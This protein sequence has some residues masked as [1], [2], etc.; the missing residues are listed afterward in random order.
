L[1]LKLLRDRD[2]P[3]VVKNGGAHIIVNGRIDFWPGTGLWIERGGPRGRG[4]K[5]LLRH[6]GAW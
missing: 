1:S 3:F 6:I 4:V 2:I 5:D